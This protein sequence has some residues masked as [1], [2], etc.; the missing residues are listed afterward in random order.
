MGLEHNASKADSGV[1]VSS[2]IHCA[3][4]EAAGTSGWSGLYCGSAKQLE[5]QSQDHAHGEVLCVSPTISQDDAVACARQ[6]YAGCETCKMPCVCWG[7]LLGVWGSQARKQDRVCSVFSAISLRSL[8]LNTPDNEKVPTDTGHR[9]LST[10]GVWA[11]QACVGQNGDLR[12][13]VHGL[14]WSSSL[15]KKRKKERRKERKKERK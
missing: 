13:Q 1:Q 10:Q 12:N 7:G 3:C 11:C 6:L 15:S 5:R 9:D 14:L 2:L 4:L 8:C